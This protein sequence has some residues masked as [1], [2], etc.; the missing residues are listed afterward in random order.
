[1]ECRPGLSPGPGRFVV[2][3]IEPMLPLVVHPDGV[4][5]VEGDGS[6]ALQ[7]ARREQ[8]TSASYT[9]AYAACIEGRGCTVK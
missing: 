2:V 1:M 8:A 9:R 7:A 4:R 6:D 5:E 3:V